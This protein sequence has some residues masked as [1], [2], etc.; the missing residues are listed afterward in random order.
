VLAAC[1]E[2]AQQKAQAQVCG[3]RSDISKQINTL[4]GLTVSITSVDEVKTG[5]EAIAED[6][7]KIKNADVNLQPQRKAQVQAATHAF[8]MQLTSILTGLTSN[9]SL[10]DA[11]AELK[12]ALTKLTTSYQQ[13]LKSVDCS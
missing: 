9:L 7:T 1:G 3:A 8:E 10:N 12:S 2:S 11:E 5:V 6:L 13:T 4:A